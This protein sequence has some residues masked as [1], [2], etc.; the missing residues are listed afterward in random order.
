M[1]LNYGFGTMTATT[2]IRKSLIQVCTILKLVEFLYKQDST[3]TF[4]RFMLSEYED[5][6]V[7]EFLEFE[8]P[9]GFSGRVERRADK[10]K[11]NI[12]GLQI[13]HRKYKSI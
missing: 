4:F 6:M 11:R 9:I 10:I 1:I 12:K 13:I 3:L 5:K 2:C 7:V 8:F